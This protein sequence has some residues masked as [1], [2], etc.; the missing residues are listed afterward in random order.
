MPDVPKT[1]TDYLDELETIAAQID[2]LL[3][4]ARDLIDAMRTEDEGE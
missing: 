4:E 1:F 3:Q 2:M